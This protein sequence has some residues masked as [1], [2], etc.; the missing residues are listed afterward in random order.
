MA[1]AAS[2]SA[3]KLRRLEAFNERDT[4]PARPRCAEGA[5][6]RPA[7]WSRRREEAWSRPTGGRAHAR[8]R[9]SPRG[10]TI[11]D[12]LNG[13]RRHL[14]TSSRS[15]SEFY[16]VRLRRLIETAV[17]PVEME[18]PRSSRRREHHRERAA[19]GHRRIAGRRRS[20]ARP[21]SKDSPR[22]CRE[23][24]SWESRLHPRAQ[25]AV[26]AASSSSAS[27]RPSSLIEEIN[28]ELRG[29]TRS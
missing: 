13:R 6:Y 26:D 23:I 17:Q 16:D 27:L 20:R 25:A 10:R 29:C 3:D 12:R 9:T 2:S 28:P 11:A 15:G 24:S 14:S 4:S 8:R 21:P 22:I 5:D 1:R 18:R 7:G 19:R